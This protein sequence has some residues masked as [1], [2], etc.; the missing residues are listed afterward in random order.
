METATDRKRIVVVDDE[1]PLLRVI[2]RS[3]EQAFTA[4]IQVFD[5]P[6]SA[7]S[8]VNANHVDVAIVDYKMPDVNG[9]DFLS[10]LKAA[11]PEMIRIIMSGQPETDFLEPA[12]NEAEVF[13]FIKKPWD[14]QELYSIVYQALKLSAQSG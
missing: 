13:R 7:M 2:K 10:A 6:F 5:N 4:D 9:V 11:R 8:F 1:K 14:V 3:L 12:I